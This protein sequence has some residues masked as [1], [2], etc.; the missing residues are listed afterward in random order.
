ME[1]IYR[2]EKG[3]APHTRTVTKIRSALEAEGLLFLEDMGVPV[4]VRFSSPPAVHGALGGSQTSAL[5]AAPL[6]PK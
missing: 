4:G 3:R 1:T 6:A 2:F 5:R